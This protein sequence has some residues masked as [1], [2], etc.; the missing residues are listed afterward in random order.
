MASYR[1]HSKGVANVG[2][3]S[4]L[5]ATLVAPLVRAADHELPEVKLRVKEGAAG[6][7]SRRFDSRV[8]TL[9]PLCLPSR[10]RS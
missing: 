4:T 8:S 6:D 3:V 1:G 5:A 9:S 2:V 10:W 7:S